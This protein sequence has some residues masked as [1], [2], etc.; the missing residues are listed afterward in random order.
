M[1]EDLLAVEIALTFKWKDWLEPCSC[2]PL[3]KETLQG[4]WETNS[5]STGRLSSF[6]S[7]TQ[8]PPRKRPFSSQGPCLAVLSICKV[9]HSPRVGCSS[10]G[11]VGELPHASS[12]PV[13]M[14]PQLINDTLSLCSTRLLNN[15][16]SRTFWKLLADCQK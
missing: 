5:I 15:P 16:I 7:T 14:D 6:G 4:R 9:A 8:A 10:L 1:V 11:V 2:W 3:G 13:Q 12:S